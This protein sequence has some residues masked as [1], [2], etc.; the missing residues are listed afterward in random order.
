MTRPRPTYAQRCT[1]ALA[2]GLHPIIFTSDLPLR[3][4]RN[5]QVVPLRRFGSAENRVVYAAP[6]IENALLA[7]DGMD[8][9]TARAFVR[10]GLGDPDVADALMAISQGLRIRSVVPAAIEQVATCLRFMRD[11]VERAGGAEKFR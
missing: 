8:H 9:W 10:I 7:F 2:R 3:G 11:A 1:S 4:L 6:W 5:R